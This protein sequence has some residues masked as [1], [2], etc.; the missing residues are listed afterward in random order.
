MNIINDTVP[1]NSS[2]FEKIVGRLLRPFYKKINAM[3]SGFTSFDKRCLVYMK[4]TPFYRKGNQHSNMWETRQIVYILNKMGYL[5]DMVSP[6]VDNYLP[7]NI[8]DL[9]IGYGS[10]NSGKYFYKYSM[11]L[12]KAKKILYAS[13]PEPTLSNRLVRE[14]YDQFNERSNL[15]AP[16]M[17]VSNI[18]FKKFISVADCI[19]CIGEKNG[20]SFDSYLKHKLP[21][22]P[23]LPS[24]IS[25]S[26][27]KIVRKKNHKHYL[28]FAGSGLICKGVD[29][30]IE[31]FKN[32][33]DYHLHICGPSEEALNSYYA[34]L[35]K[36][37]K[38]IRFYGFVDIEGSQYKELINKCSFTILH[39]A[40]EGCVTS[41]VE[42]MSKG[43]VPIVNYECGISINGFGYLISNNKNKVQA[44][45]EAILE[46]GSISKNEYERKVNL[47]I[48]ASKKYSKQ[49]FTKYFETALLEVMK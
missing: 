37:S 16:Y 12:T 3:S 36:T 39:S 43:L 46:T 10:G 30:L 45:K 8:Y 2:I 13:G 48:K 33:P 7:K 27:P 5:V 32:M 6:E 15:E 4:T 26:D 29:I 21:I 19:F 40:A 9:F 14:R 24:Y 41:I 47:T 44:I 31:A 20:F 22:Y 18:D 1:G 23:I 17:R 25:E 28:C 38:N 35:F 34:D 11:P 42:N 49:I